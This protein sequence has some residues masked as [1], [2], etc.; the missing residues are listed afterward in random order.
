MTTV[1]ITD[2]V[3]SA[4]HEHIAAH[5]PERG[6]ALFGPRSSDTWISHFV[7]DQEGKTTG[8]SYTPSTWLVKAV[9]ELERDTGLAFRGIVHSHPAGFARPSLVDLQAA[10]QFLQLNPTLKKM[11]LPIVTQSIDTN[12]SSWL[13]WYCIE[14][15]PTDETIESR[16]D[17]L[18]TSH[19]RVVLNPATPSIMRVSADMQSMGMTTPGRILSVDGS[20]FATI[21]DID[22]ANVAFVIDE[23]YPTSA[24]LIV[25][26]EDYR[27]IVSRKWPAVGGHQAGLNALGREL[28]DYL[29]TVRAKK[30][31]AN[32][33]E[34]NGSLVV[35]DVETDGASPVVGDDH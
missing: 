12:S 22:G 24:P 21:H 1:K 33:S 6:G 7:Y 16:C 27:A 9:P 32:D 8:I 30:T 15:K 18:T 28:A 10:R 23:H 3:I 4:L 34:N 13:K 17:N 29:K 14:Q 19:S 35:V 25:V 11:H 5:G 26:G 20:S 31:V 2:G